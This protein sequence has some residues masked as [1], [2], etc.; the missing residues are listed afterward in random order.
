MP[1]LTFTQSIGGRGEGVLAHA[2]PQ[3]TFCDVII[4]QINCCFYKSRRQCNL[5]KKKYE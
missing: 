5:I 2:L 1:W 3:T 4:Y